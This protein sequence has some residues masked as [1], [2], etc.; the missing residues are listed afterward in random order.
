MTDFENRLR[1]AMQSSVAA[2]DPPANLVAQ[3]RRRHRRHMVRLGVIGV[4]VAIAAAL[5]VSPAR[6]ALLTDVTTRTQAPT[7]TPRGQTFGC[8]SQTL[9]ALQ[10]NWRSLAVH[11]GPLWIINR[12]IGP[13]F[14][15]HNPDGTLKAVPLIVLLQDNV[16][17]SVE[18]T[19]G[20]QPYFRFLAGFN[21]TDEYTMSDGLPSATFTACSARAALFG[22]GLTEYYLG[23]IVAGPRCITLDVLTSAGQPPH[24]ATLQFGRCN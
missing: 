15:F 21:A 24:R 13:G 22:E 8:A 23:V 9:G 5:A 18:P 4:A 17:V 3:V 11:A 19:A 6:S 7:T 2:E 16:T 14:D 10:S 1:A 12:G 20:G